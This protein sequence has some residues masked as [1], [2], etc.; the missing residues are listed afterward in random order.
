MANSTASTKSSLPSQ[1]NRNVGRPSR[2]GLRARRRTLNVLRMLVF[3][4]TVVYPSVGN[5]GRKSCRCVYSL[6]PC[7]DK[8]RAR[9]YQQSLPRRTRR[10][11]AAKCEMRE[12]R[13]A[14]SSCTRLQAR[15]K[16]LLRLSQLQVSVST[17][18]WAL[19]VRSDVLG[20]LVTWPPTVPNHALLKV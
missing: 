4:S 7:V 17:L 3:R 6:E 18:F 13:R 2:D 11:G 10:E 20:N 16:R 19:A 8:F 14:W 9:P 15:A 5:C 1:T 12:L